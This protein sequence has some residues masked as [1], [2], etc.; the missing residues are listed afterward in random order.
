M[1]PEYLQT[2]IPFIVTDALKGWPRDNTGQLVFSIDRLNEL[3][4][5]HTILTEA[6]YECE[7]VSSMKTKGMADF[8]LFVFNL[9]RCQI[10][11]FVL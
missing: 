10:F 8:S 9:M 4:K 6:A 1:V 3:F 7:F 11:D 5:K 2:D